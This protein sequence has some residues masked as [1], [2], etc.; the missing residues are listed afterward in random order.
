VS[1]FRFS[2]AGDGVIGRYSVKNSAKTQRY[3]SR[4]ESD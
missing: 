1:E 4:T 3:S 2:L